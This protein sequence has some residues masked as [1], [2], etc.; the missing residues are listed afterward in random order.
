[1]S[2]GPLF[3]LFIGVGALTASACTGP[4]ACDCVDPTLHVR[5]PPDLAG[6][7]MGVILGGACA[8]QRV[9]CTM[10]SGSGCAEYAFSASMPGT[11]H[12]DMDFLTG[13]RFSADIKIVHTAGC[14][15]GFF[16]EPPSAGDVQVP[17]MD[18][19]GG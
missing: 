10:A 6:A 12:L 15:S 5:V 16:A 13:R 9:S 19:G 11:C 1:M 4:T 8:D 14:C 3:A 7:A 17:E 2:L 18:G